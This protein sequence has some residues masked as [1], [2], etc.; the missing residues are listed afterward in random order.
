MQMKL[1]YDAIACYQKALTVAQE[2]LQE[3]T[4]HLS[5]SEAIHYLCPFMSQS[6]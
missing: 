2:V 1:Y 5:N 3:A 4:C 6:C